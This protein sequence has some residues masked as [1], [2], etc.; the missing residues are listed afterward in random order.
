V[1]YQTVSATHTNW[2]AQVTRTASEAGG[3]YQ[4]DR[5]AGVVQ[6]NGGIADGPAS[7]DAIRDQIKFIDHSQLIDSELQYQ[8]KFGGV[9][10]ITGLQLRLYNPRSEGSYLADINGTVL[11]ATEFG[12][13]AQADYS[14][15]RDTLRLVAAARVDTH[16]N[17]APQFSPKGA[18][19]YS[20]SRTQHLRVGYNRAFKSPT[21]LENYLFI[22]NSLLGNRTGFLIKDAEGNLLSEIRPLVPEQVD[23]V[24]L[25]YKA[26]FF[27]QL[28]VDVVGYHSWYRDF[29]SSLTART[30]PAQGT[31]AHY[32]DGRRVAEGTATEGALSTY[33]NFGR[34]RVAGVDLG[35]EYQLNPNILLTGS[36]SYIGLLSFRSS[37]P[38][39]K[40]LLLNVPDTKLKAS[41]T[42]QDLG[43]KG[44]F[45][46]LFGRYQSAY[47]FTSGRWNSAVFFPDGK[48]P[49]RFV[50]DLGLGY[51][52]D[53]GLAVSGNVFNLLDDKGVDVLGTAP[54][55]RSAYVQ[56]AYSYKGLDF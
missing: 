29:I 40:A 26:T 17:Y 12:G 22:N 27:N 13:Y 39:Q 5:L 49:A 32:P 11:S 46:R 10:V 6:T 35:L 44:S 18:V 3:T 45:V 55:G 43:L 51:T 50:A 28:L 47:E 34:S 25:G 52:F 31:F 8:N 48:I 30:N 54:N 24:E 4:L 16:S 14:L 41:I 1:H 33:S 9:N 42:L 2:F 36:A 19:V 56:L 21:I 7:L 23:S 15:L 20:L 38:T 53:N 37:D